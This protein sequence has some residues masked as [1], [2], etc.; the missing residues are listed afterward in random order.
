M[1]VSNG[2]NIGFSGAVSF[3]SNTAVVSEV[4]PMSTVRGQGEGRESSPCH[5][6]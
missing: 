6:G 4:L 2:Y 3:Q 5:C 1:Y